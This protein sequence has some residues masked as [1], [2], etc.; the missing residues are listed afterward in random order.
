MI[1]QRIIA[2]RTSFYRYEGLWRSNQENSFPVSDQW[3]C[4]VRMRAI[5]SLYNA[6]ETVGVL[7]NVSAKA[8]FCER[9]LQWH[10]QTDNFDRRSLNFPTL[11]SAT[12][13]RRLKWYQ[14]MLAR[15]SHYTIYL[16]TLLGSF[17]WENVADFELNGSLS[18]RALPTLRQLADDLTRLVPMSNNVL[19]SSKL[20]FLSVTK[21]S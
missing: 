16:A 19:S 11:E 10:R 13:E 14:S 15:P 5:C 2:M 9:S 12:R 8:S 3:S 7:K 4:T 18:H 1:R 17:E 6:V 20:V 21:C